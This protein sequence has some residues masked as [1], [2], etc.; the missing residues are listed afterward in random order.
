[1]II[2][3]SLD[4]CVYAADHGERQ[5]NTRGVHSIVILTLTSPRAGI[6][7]DTDEGKNDAVRKSREVTTNI[8]GRERRRQEQ[9]RRGHTLSRAVNNS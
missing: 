9:W 2:P 7:N 3:F 4:A 6:A 8:T 1:M 5:G